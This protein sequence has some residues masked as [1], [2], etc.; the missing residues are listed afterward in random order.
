MDVVPSGYLD[1]YERVPLS[2][3]GYGF[4]VVRLHK[5]FSCTN[6]FLGKIS[7]KKKKKKGKFLN[8]GFP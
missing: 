6:A 3:K 8:K 5:M 1:L 4:E 2:E 7:L